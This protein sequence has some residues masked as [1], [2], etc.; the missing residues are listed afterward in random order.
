MPRLAGSPAAS[1][2]SKELPPLAAAEVLLAGRFWRVVCAL[3]MIWEIWPDDMD[4]APGKGFPVEV[5]T[6]RVG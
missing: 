1:S 3:S 2:W 6:E 4:P 5:K